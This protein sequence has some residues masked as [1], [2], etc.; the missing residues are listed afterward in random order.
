MFDCHYHFLAHLNLQRRSR[1]QWPRAHLPVRNLLLVLKSLNPVLVQ[2]NSI[3]MKSNRITF[4]LY[5]ILRIVMMQILRVTDRDRGGSQLLIMHHRTGITTLS[6]TPVP[7]DPRH[8]RR[9]RNALRS[10]PI[11]FKYSEAD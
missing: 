5:Q 4:V 6:T 1:G 9:Y 3:T 8:K 10:V 7:T 2:E 11:I